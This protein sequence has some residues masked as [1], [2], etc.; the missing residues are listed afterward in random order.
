MLDLLRGVP[1]H[2]VQPHPIRLDRACQSY[3]MW[4]RIFVEDWNG[5]SFFPPPTN[6][7]QL[8]TCRGHGAVVLGTVAAGFS[9]GGM[10]DQ[11]IS[12]KSSSR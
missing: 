3:V 4:W 12:P 8:Q 6:L 11:R 10:R 5:I 7:P 1:M 2:R 9:S